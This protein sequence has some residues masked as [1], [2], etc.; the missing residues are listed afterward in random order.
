MAVIRVEKL[1]FIQPNCSGSM[2]VDETL[3]QVTGNFSRHL[4]KIGVSEVGWRSL[5][6]LIAWYHPWQ[7][8]D[9]CC[10][11]HFWYIG[12]PDTAIED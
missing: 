10:F 1:S 6:N 2:S 7:R 5:R 12:L 4:G 11:P 8:C 9:I 3:T